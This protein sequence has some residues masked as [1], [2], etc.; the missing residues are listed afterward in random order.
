[1]SLITH[2]NAELQVAYYGQHVTATPQQGGGRQPKILVP[3]FHFGDKLGVQMGL[4]QI[5]DSTTVYF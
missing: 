2:R 1:M 4:K 5:W 3:G